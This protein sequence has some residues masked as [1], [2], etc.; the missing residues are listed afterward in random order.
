[1]NL[2]V[3]SAEAGEAGMGLDSM[4][5]TIEGDSVEAVLGNQAK[6]LA[7][8]E[9]KKHGMHA[10]GIEGAGGPFPVDSKTNQPVPANGMSEISKRAADLRY[11]ITYKLTQSVI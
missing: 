8:E 1:M 4:F 2:K 3:V 7:Y 10:A 9:R 11:R 5:V 6:Q